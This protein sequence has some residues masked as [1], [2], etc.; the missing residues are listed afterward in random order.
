MPRLQL[1]TLN[2]TK[3]D[4]DVYEILLP[5]TEGQIGIF[6]NH[7]PMMAQAAE[8]I[9]KV[10]RKQGEPDDLMVAYACHG[11]VIEVADE[12]VKVLTDEADRADELVEAQ[13]KAAYE[14][15]LK[16]RE[17]AKDLISLEKAQAQIDRAAIRLNVAKLRKHRH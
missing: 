16:L 4:E 5:T 11:G 7:A 17:Q 14:A 12:I 13:E 10:R 8:G 9:I 6:A 1:V 15:A 3:L 2:G